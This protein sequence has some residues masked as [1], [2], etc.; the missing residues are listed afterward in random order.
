MS[1]ETPAVNADAAA[2]YVRQAFQVVHSFYLVFALF[3]TQVSEGDVFKLQPPVTATAVVEREHDI[4]LIGHIDVPA[5]CV[6]HPAVGNHL[7]MRTAIY[8][9][10]CRIFLIRVEVGRLYKAVI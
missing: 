3:N 8:I 2:V 4:T 5:A 1:A 7:G 10:D 6:I 9:D